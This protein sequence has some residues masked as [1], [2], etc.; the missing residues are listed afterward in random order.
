MHASQQPTA[1]VEAMATAGRVVHFSAEMAAYLG[2]R[3]SGEEAT[4]TVYHE[5]MA[6][7]EELASTL[8]V[9]D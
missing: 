6:A 4:A 5:E 3:R 9:V 1:E 8:S 7:K 2:T